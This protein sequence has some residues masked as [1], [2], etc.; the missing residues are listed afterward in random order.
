MKQ[1]TFREVL[2][3][4]LDVLENSLLSQAIESDTTFKAESMLRTT[5]KS[6]FIKKGIGQNL[7]YLLQQITVRITHENTLIV[8]IRE[9]VM[10]K[11]EEIYEF[12]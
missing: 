8:D 9:S 10:E 1:Q 4:C 11:L 6:A 7:D 3:E 5:L 2:S 12:I